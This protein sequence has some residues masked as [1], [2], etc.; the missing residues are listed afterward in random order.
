MTLEE[1]LLEQAHQLGF[2]LAGIAAAQPSDQY[3]LYRAW[4]EAGY[5]GELAYLYKHAEARRDLSQ[6]YAPAQAVVM[7]ALNYNPGPEAPSGGLARYARTADYHLVLRERLKKLGGWLREQVPEAWGRVC[8]DTAPLLERDFARRAGLGW[9]AKNTMLIH[10]R[11]GSWFVLGALLVNLPL[12]PSA[13]FTKMHCGTCTR[14]LDACPT[15]AFVAPQVLDARRCI[16][17]WTIE[18]RRPLHNHEATQLHGWLFGCDICQEVCPWNRKAPR[19]ELLVPRQDLVGLDPAELLLLDE[20]AFRA[21]FEG[22]AL[23]PRPG[24]PVVLRNAALLLGQAGDPAALTVLRRAAA[25]DEALIAEAARWAIARI[26]AKTSPQESIAIPLLSGNQS[27]ES[28]QEPSCNAE[29]TST[30]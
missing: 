6:L 26:E 12:Q 25:E 10:P 9:Q 19:A 11:L 8:V 13:P 17:T 2:D 23:Y 30:P 27:A 22:T 21:R 28:S 20:A 1:R 7:V 24:R 15:G 18:L 29:P 4:L 5:A 14:C 3:V 16:S